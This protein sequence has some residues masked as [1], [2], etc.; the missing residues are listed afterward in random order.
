MIA[1]YL[2]AVLL[3]S[4]THLFA[5]ELVIM[6][7]Y[8]VGDPS[9]HLRTASGREEDAF[10]KLPERMPTGVQHP[11]NLLLEGGPIWGARRKSSMA[12]Q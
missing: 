7:I 3:L 8:G 2:S 5:V 9:H 10:G 12:G 1:E 4:N 11:A 6:T